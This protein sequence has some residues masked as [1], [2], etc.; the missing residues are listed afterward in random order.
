MARVRNLRA[1]LFLGAWLFTL[2]CGPRAEEP[3]LGDSVAS[4]AAG[5][6]ASAAPHA[7]AGAPATPTLEVPSG[8]HRPLYPGK[9]EPAELEVA[10]FRIDR[11]PVTNAQF[12]AFVHAHPEWRRSR[13]PELFADAAYLEHW[14][15][16]LAFEPDA[17]NAPVT[18][19]SWF[20]ARA[21]ADWRGLRL[22]TLA[23]WEYVAAASESA[24]YGRDEHGFEQRIL[25]WYA[26]KT[27]A[28]LPRVERGEPN[29]HGVHDLHGLVW[30]WVDDFNAALVTGESR[31]DAGL[32]RGLFCGS[33]SI[34]AADP[35]DYAAFMRFAFRSSLAARYCV[36]NLGFRCAEALPAAPD[37]EPSR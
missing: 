16:D 31:G 4:V 9:D 8:I 12:L 6:S 19:V 10:A 22:P 2:G 21:Y 35:S 34:G 33:G 28:V 15:G 17:A 32:D 29:F 5:E 30:E 36:P 26:E 14:T 1:L 37:P 13:V 3:V 11:H 18:S 24:A 25:D 7:F 27:P 23:E 20:A